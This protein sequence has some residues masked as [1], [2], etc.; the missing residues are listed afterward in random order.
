[1]RAG[2]PGDR[3]HHGIGPVHLEL[4]GTVERVAEAKAEVVA[5]LPEG[6][7]AVAPDEPLLEPYLARD[8]IQVRRFRPEDVLEFEPAEE[9]A[10]VRLKWASAK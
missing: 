2:A 7:T 10:H 5:G 8:D 6:G 1:M 4:L 3:R 9:T